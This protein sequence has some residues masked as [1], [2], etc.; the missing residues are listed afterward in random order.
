MSLIGGRPE[1]ITVNELIRALQGI[2][3][4]QRELPIKAEGCDC[5]NPVNRVEVVGDWIMIGVEL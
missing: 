5:I 4:E 2:S 3:P 1:G